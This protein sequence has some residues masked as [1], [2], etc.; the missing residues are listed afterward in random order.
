[1]AEPNLSSNDFK[2]TRP[3]KRQLYEFCHPLRQSNELN[4]VGVRTIF[5][6]ADIM[7]LK[8]IVFYGST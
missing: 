7:H 4:C 8:K 6:K 3:A 2:E 1:M 5:T